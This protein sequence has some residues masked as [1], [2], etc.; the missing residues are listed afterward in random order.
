MSKTARKPEEI[1]KVR[2]KII[3]QAADILSNEGYEN[4]TMRRIA[5]A[6]NMSATNIY[7]YFSNKDEIYIYV[8]IS[9]FARLFE[10]MSSISD[11]SLPPV[12]KGRRM[13]EAYLQFGIENSH[14]YDIMYSRPT[15]KYN[16]YIGT[17]LERIAVVEMNY[18]E[19]TKE[20]ASRA[21]SSLI[22]INK[23]KPSS[24]ELT[25]E[26]LKVWSTLH[27]L[28]VLHNSRIIEY[29]SSEPM[30][31]YGKIIRDIVKNYEQLSEK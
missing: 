24:G 23:R 15:P 29:I 28:I 16:D 14:Y 26:L 7:N 25:L 1:E 3:E 20:I 6:M 18:S 30:K 9:G 21:L 10:I 2:D 12:K 5:A 19:K 31:L 8:L 13:M 22:S 4:L 27:G 17:P 11:S